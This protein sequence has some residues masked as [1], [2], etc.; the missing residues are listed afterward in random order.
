MK[1]KIFALVLLA[2]ISDDDP[3][4]FYRNLL[5]LRETFD[6]IDGDGE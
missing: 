6:K 4:G 3:Y 5:K 1:M 2:L